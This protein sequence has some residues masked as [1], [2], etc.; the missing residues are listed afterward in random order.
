MRHSFLGLALC[1]AAGAAQAQAVPPYVPEQTVTPSQTREGVPETLKAPATASD[2][3]VQG[4]AI[5]RFRAAYSARKSPRIAIFWNRALTDDVEAAKLHVDSEVRAA[6]RGGQVSTSA[7]GGSST[8]VQPYGYG[9]LVQKSAGANAET[10]FGSAGVATRDRVSADV[11]QG[12][13]ARA[14]VMGEQDSWHF[15]DAFS[16]PFI[17]AGAKLVDRNTMIRIAGETADKQR[18]ESAALAG[19]AD[20]FIEVLVSVDPTSPSGYVFRAT[21]KDVKTGQIVAET[22]SDGAVPE[23]GATEYVATDHGFVARPSRTAG[24]A[25]GTT[26]AIALMDRLSQAW[27]Q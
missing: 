13:G 19:L 25:N 8:N 16:D 11:Q 21:A 10:S 27:Q 7:T 15:Q 2:P 22:I 20:L 23:S 6:A 14:A 1:L 12:F 18:A 4:E 3:A 17:K 26:V 9:Q 24:A 5:G